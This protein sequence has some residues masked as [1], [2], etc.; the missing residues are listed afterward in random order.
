MLRQ[1]GLK[2]REDST[3]ASIGCSISGSGIDVGKRRYA[4]R[5]CRRKG[6][7][8]ADAFDPVFIDAEANGHRFREMHVDGGTA[9]PLFAVPVRLLAATGQVG[10]HRGGQ[11]YIIINNNLEPE[12]AVTKPK[13]LTIVARAFNTLVKSDFYDT[14][15]DSY[16]FAK[17]QGFAFNLAYIPNTFH[18]KSVGLV[19]QKYMI[20]LFEFGHA[21]G[22]RGGHWRHTPPRLYR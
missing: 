17:E 7:F 22:V 10:G 21:Q 1:Q 6:F 15:L 13:T 12:F 16:V 8:L 9:Y 3:A 18:L 4:T 2:Q 14:I 19:D 20:T 11:L 5:A